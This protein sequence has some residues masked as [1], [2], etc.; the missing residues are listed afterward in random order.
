MESCEQSD[1]ANL[2]KP[3]TDVSSTS[4]IDSVAMSNP[5]PVQPA[6]GITNGWV[7]SSIEATSI[8]PQSSNLSPASV[9]TV[10]SQDLCAA[11]KKPTIPEWFLQSKVRLAKDLLN[12]LPSLSKSVEG[13]DN[14]EETAKE[15]SRG[16]TIILNNDYEIHPDLYAEARDTI[17]SGILRTPGNIHPSSNW[18]NTA[19]L[20]LQSPQEGSLGF[21]KAVVHTIAQELK[22]DLVS[23]GQEDAHDLCQYFWPDL[24]IDCEGEAIF[25]GGNI[26]LFFEQGEEQE[27]DDKSSPTRMDTF[28]DTLLACPKKKTSSPVHR[29]PLI[30]HLPEVEDFIDSDEGL[31]PFFRKL[32]EAVKELRK[33]GKTTIIVGTTVWDPEEYGY[34]NQWEMH[35]EDEAP[36]VY[37][38]VVNI[39]PVATRRAAVTLDREIKGEPWSTQLR[40]LRR[41]LRWSLGR[42][43]QSEFLLP[44][45]LWELPDSAELKETLESWSDEIMGRLVRQIYARIALTRKVEPSEIFDIIARISR[46]KSA[47]ERN[48]AMSDQAEEGPES[49]DGN[50]KK[51][52]E[53]EEQESSEEEET[54]EEEEDNEEGGVDKEV[55]SK[56]KF[57]TFLENLSASC[58]KEEEGL[59]DCVV[60]PDSLKSSFESIKLN[61]DLIDRLRQLLSHSMRESEGLLATETVNGSILY[62]PPGTG[63]THLARILAKE[64]AANFIS[65]NPA[66]ME[67]C[68]VG[69]TEQLIKALFS[70]ARKLHP[71]VIFLDEADALFGRRTSTDRK[72]ER[73][74]LSQFLV[75]IE[76][77]R[78]SDKSPFVLMATNRPA[79]MDDAICRRL[80]HIV[81][82]GLPGVDERRGIFA[83]FLKEE[84]VDADVNLDELAGTHTREFSG[85]DIRALCVQAALIA[86]REVD[87][88]KDDEVT[89]APR[90]PDYHSEELLQMGTKSRARW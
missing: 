60:D 17:L 8:D 11:E 20:L 2:S 33:R 59:F 14:G 83:I 22:A 40:H 7:D 42:Q 43:L 30:I 74:S 46:N 54:S 5:D 86:Q 1:S 84:R 10:Q 70:L 12:H 48:K 90:G 66:D 32:L 18:V 85:S 26:G 41:A 16:G 64:A 89:D 61:Q 36:F 51:A 13:K 6:R 57:Q 29:P 44:E 71:C 88:V 3:A 67:R 9:K 49:K 77:L 37:G 76:G 63:K 55:K 65:I 4:T 38:T 19:A 34:S 50:S 78:R 72:W 15:A 35:G 73:T 45:A 81:H 58:T 52:D 23:L 24:S 75:E 21:S 79:N 25:S 31:Q 47:I 87:L 69:E 39:S 82:I 27:K 28:I 56:S 80:P 62:G 68:Y 53:E